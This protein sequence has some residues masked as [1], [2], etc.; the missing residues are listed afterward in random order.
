MESKN[1]VVYLLS[2]YFKPALNPGKT[3]SVFILSRKK[4]Q[5]SMKYLKHKVEALLNIQN[6]HSLI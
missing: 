2:I 6:S 5:N 3:F 1:I 4:T